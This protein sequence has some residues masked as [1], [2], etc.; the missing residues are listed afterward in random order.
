MERVTMD[1][2]STTSTLLN[3]ID[4]KECTKNDIAMTYRLAMESEDETDWK[5][6]NLAIIDRWSVSALKDIKELAWSGKCFEENRK[7][8]ENLREE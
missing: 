7:E 4:H 6:V 2:M 5:K 8:L 1:L 3:E